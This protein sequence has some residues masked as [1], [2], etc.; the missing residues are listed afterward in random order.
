MTTDETS[1]NAPNDPKTMAPAVLEQHTPAI[2]YIDPSQS[3]II[4]ES[5]TKNPTVSCPCLLL[6]ACQ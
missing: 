1:A 2:R 4:M 6:P 3:N 5:G